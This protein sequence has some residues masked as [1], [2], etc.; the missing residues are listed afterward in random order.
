MGYCGFG[1]LAGHMP[2]AGIV[3]I[4]ALPA[5]GTVEPKFVV[6]PLNVLV[7][8]FLEQE[9]LPAVRRSADEG[10]L[11]MGLVVSHMLA[12]MRLVA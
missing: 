3:A 5:F 12:T 1:V 2:K 4:V 6:D 8:I 10:T 11:T 9:A 7:K